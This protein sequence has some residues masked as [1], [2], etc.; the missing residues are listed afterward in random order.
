[1]RP[2]RKDGR[3]FIRVWIAERK[4]ASIGVHRSREATTHGFAVNVDN[5][6][7]P[8]EWSARRPARRAHD[9]DHA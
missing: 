2:L 1:M 5:H 8:F 6:L 7:Y 3:D 9:V 4:I